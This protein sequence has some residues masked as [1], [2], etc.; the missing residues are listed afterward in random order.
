MNYSKRHYALVSPK[1]D[2]P[3]REAERR[4]HIANGKTVWAEIQ[5]KWPRITADNFEE[6]EAYRLARLREL[7]RS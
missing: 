5:A 1:P 3:E 6:V 2:T 4:Q 7:E